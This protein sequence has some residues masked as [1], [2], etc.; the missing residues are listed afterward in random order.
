[1]K[2]AFSIFMSFVMA[3]CIFGNLPLKITANANLA[4]DIFTVKTDGYSCKGFITYVI[5]IKKGI[6][7]CGTVLRFRYDTSVLEV[8]DCDAYMKTDS[9]GNSYQNISGMYVDGEAV[10]SENEYTIA[11][12]NFSDYNVKSSDKEFVQI[13]FKLKDNVFT[14]FSKTSIEFSCFEFNSETMPELNITKGDKQVITT[15]S[16]LPTEH[17]FKNNV[18]SA[19]GALCFE[20]VTCEGGVCVTKYNGRESN[21]IIPSSINGHPV[22]RIGNGETSVAGDFVDMTI[23]SSVKSIAENAFL[24]TSYYSDP[25]NWVDDVL[26]F[27][28]YLIATK[29][30]PSYYYI[31]N[32]VKII[33]DGA[34]KDYDSYILCEKNSVAHNYAKANGIKYIYPTLTPGNS[35]TVI[36]FKN[37]LIFTSVLECDDASSLV[38][39][40]QTV[41]LYTSSGNYFGTGATF[42]V[43]DN[44]IFMG[45]YHLIAEADLD[46]DGVCD[47]IDATLAS[48][49]LEQYDYPTN[50]EIYAANGEISNQI[51]ILSYQNVVNSALK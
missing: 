40:P 4:T 10:N 51:D 30:P 26:Y 20:Y 46:G 18:C 41:T 45:S 47:V 15:S 44:G 6:S 9:D 3:F 28:N 16:V 17:T 48:R 22:V 24:E 35:N 8:S 2:K 25:T 5:S 32:S 33:A 19:C 34:F 21:C 29:N 23:P 7:F 36:D 38:S 27:R 50:Y 14:P 43:Y 12:I 42:T 13:T 11:Y 37:Q 1:M 49:Y 31:D 39:L